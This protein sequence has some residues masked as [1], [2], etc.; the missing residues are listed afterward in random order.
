[1]Q[2]LFFP[3]LQIARRG[4]A[5]LSEEILIYPMLRDEFRHLEHADLALPLNTGLSASSALI[6]I[7]FV[8]HRAS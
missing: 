2:P 7:L 3:S 6:M 4:N 8:L 5:G 1:V